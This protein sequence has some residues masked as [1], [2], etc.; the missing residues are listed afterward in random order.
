MP[1]TFKD[2]MALIAER[3]R[4]AENIERILDDPDHPH[5]MKALEFV[6]NRGIGPVPKEIQ[7]AAELSVVIRN[8]AANES[9]E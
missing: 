3:G 2:R 5:F 6:A 8:E 7:M 1:N 4:T 9:A